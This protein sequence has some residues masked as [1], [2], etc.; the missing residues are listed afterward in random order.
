MSFRRT[1]KVRY[2]ECD[3]QGEAF[4]NRQR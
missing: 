3:M 1:I 4:L 2:G